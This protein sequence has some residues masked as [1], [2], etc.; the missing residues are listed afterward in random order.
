MEGGGSRAAR[1]LAFA[2]AFAFERVDH[3]CTGLNAGREGGEKGQR[4]FF[5]PTHNPHP[6]SD[7]LFFPS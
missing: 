5:S 2:F 4:R 7:A 3:P 6:K 1:K